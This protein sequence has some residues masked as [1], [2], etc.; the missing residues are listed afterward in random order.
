MCVCV[1]VQ[2]FWGNTAADRPAN[3]P[4]EPIPPTSLL[5]GASR[6]AS[7]FHSL[8][9]TCETYFHRSSPS[10]GRRVSHFTNKP[11]QCHHHL[12]RPPPH[13]SSHTL[14]RPHCDCG[15]Q[16]LPAPPTAKLANSVTYS[17]F[18]A[19]LFPYSNIIDQHAL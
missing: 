16:H 8:V 17:I 5:S 14:T 2:P 19:T 10:L 3:T 11:L 18:I 13:T 4:Q 9:L 7:P 12:H 15:T 6:D 1:C